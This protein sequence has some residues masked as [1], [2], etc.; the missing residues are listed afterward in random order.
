MNEDLIVCRCE[1]ITEE[2]IIR[3]I[4]EGA[5]SLEELKRHLR[6]GMGPCQGR[7]CGPL[8]IRL[9]CQELK[10]RPEDFAEWRKRPPLKPVT[11]GSLIPKGEPQA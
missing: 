10:A 3:A 11:L 2:E 6:V 1:E 8:L 7:T 4:R 5:Q 9:L